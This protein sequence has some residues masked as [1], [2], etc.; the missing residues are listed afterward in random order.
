MKKKLNEIIQF[1]TKKKKGFILRVR[2]FSLRLEGNPRPSSYPVITGD[3]FR[4][5]AKHI[6]DETTSFMPGAVSR[7]DIVFVSQDK[8]LWYLQDMHPNILVPYILIVHNGDQTFDERYTAL[9]DDNIIHC[10][11]QNVNVIH[12]KVTA[13]PIGL[14]NF[15]HFVHTDLPYRIPPVCVP[16]NQQ[17]SKKNKFFYRFL[18]GNCPSVRIPLRTLCDKH[19]LMETVIEYVPESQFRESFQKYKFIITPRGNAID[20]SHR[21]YEALHLGCIPVVQDSIVVQSLHK[22]GLPLWIVK[23]WTELQNVS[24]ADIAAKYAE[25]MKNAKF[26]AMHMDYWITKIKNDQRHMQQ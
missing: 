3:S 7:G 5:L 6:H 19:P 11:A 16:E 15:Y 17:K 14:A 22:E 10:Y 24:E 2:R 18:N 12:E 13:I 4:A 9:L 8:A 26:D 25:L 21:Q 1:L 23:D 20:N